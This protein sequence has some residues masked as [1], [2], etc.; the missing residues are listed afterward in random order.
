MA[1]QT[2]SLAADTSGHSFDCASVCRSALAFGHPGSCSYWLAGRNCDRLGSAFVGDSSTLVKSLPS[3]ADHRF[4]LGTLSRHRA[5]RIWGILAQVTRRLVVCCSGLSPPELVL[6]RRLESL[7][8]DRGRVKRKVAP[9]PGLL[10]AEMWPPSASI[11]PR[12]IDSPSPEP[13]VSFVR[14]WSVR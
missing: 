9:S 1:T 7:Y 13:P 5:T 10:S 14:D 8:T 2:R 6:S 3:A 12:A 4:E 11:M